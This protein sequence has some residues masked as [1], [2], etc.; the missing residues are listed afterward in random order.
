MT[1][2]VA[3]ATG[4]TG[5]LLVREL[6]DREEQVRVIVRSTARLPAEVSGHENLSATE[7]SILDLSDSELL[8]QVSGCA[9]LI[10][11]GSQAELRWR[12]WPSSPARNRCDAQTVRC[13]QSEQANCPGKV[14][15]DKHS[16]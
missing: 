1:I 16:R 13:D 10:L 2:L 12:V 3:G 15:T 8:A 11:P 7:A 5:S 14:C 9:A 4:A 6:L